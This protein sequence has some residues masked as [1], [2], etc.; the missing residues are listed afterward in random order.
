MGL[1]LGST[2]NSQGNPTELLAQIRRRAQVLLRRVAREPV[3][4]VFADG[5]LDKNL[6]SLIGAG[7]GD[8]SNVKPV[9]A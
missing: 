6:M 4:G 2:G 5:I 7:R 1:G 8:T 3:H 9:Q